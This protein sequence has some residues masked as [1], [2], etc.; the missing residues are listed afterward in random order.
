QFRDVPQ[1]DRPPDDHADMSQAGAPQLLQHLRNQGPVGT[2]QEAQ[3]EPVGVLVGDGAD[4]RF[5]RLPE[6]GIDDVETGI[7]Q[8]PR[9]DLDAPIVSIEADLGQDD[10]HRRFLVR[11]GS[12]VTRGSGGSPLET[13]QELTTWRRHRNDRTPRPA[14][15]SLPRPWRGPGPRPAME[16]PG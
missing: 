2:A 7:A 9:H 8:G 10:A 14:R 15:P 6:P 13:R 12:L 1:G 5:R 11:H 4:D 3:A 16:V